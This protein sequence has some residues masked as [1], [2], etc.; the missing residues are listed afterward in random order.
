MQHYEQEPYF[1]DP[2]LKRIHDAYSL[3]FLG[4]FLSYFTIIAA[5]IIALLHRPTVKNSY[6]LSHIDYILCGCVYYTAFIAASI[7]IIIWN[8]QQSFF[9][10]GNLI[11][12]GFLYIFFAFFPFVWWVRRFLRGLAYF[13]ARQPI[14]QPY[15][16]WRPSKLRT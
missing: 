2:S 1:Q 7:G 9:S 16:P 11:V 10:Q 6:L 3:C 8:Y 15:S 13:K 5:F 14:P 4:L 12:G